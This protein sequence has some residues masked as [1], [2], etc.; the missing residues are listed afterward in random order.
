MDHLRDVINTTALVNYLSELI[1]KSLIRAFDQAARPQPKKPAKKKKT[2][3][4]VV[5]IKGKPTVKI[6]HKVNKATGQVY[7]RAYVNGKGYV[8][9]NKLDLIKLLEGMGME[10]INA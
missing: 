9:A 8:R 4:P 6:H 5:T 10:A 2:K 1:H 3:K 7:F